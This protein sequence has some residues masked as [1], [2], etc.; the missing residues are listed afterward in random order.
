MLQNVSFLT[1]GRPSGS[2]V[3]IG[4]GYTTVVTADL[5]KSIGEIEGAVTVNGGLRWE[6][7]FGQQV[8]NGALSIF[9]MDNWQKGV[10]STVYHNAPAG[11]LWPGDPGFPSQAGMLKQWDNLGP[12]VGISWDP[13]GDGRTSVRASYGAACR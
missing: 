6:P 3:R 4:E 7:Y 2:I 8:E 12:R 5:S 10:K 11:F 13:S 9:N 1:D